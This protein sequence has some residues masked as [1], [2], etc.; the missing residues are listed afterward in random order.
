MSEHGITLTEAM[1]IMSNVMLFLITFGLI[2]Q[3][4]HKDDLLAKLIKTLVPHIRKAKKRCSDCIG[5]HRVK[6]D[7]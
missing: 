7:A 3:N 1:I 2:I 4:W 5:R 6:H